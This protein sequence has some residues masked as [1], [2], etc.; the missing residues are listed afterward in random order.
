MIRDISET[1]QSL[2]ED[3]ALAGEF[4]DLAGAQISFERPA[5]T[6]N[7]PQTTVDLFLY[8]IKENTVLRTNEPVI[9]RTG[10]LA[11]VSQPP[12]RIDCSYLVTAFPVGGADVALQEHRLLS[13][14]LQV[15]SRHPT[16]P[17]AHLQG[18]LVSQEPPLPLVA[19]QI[20]GLPNVG[21]FWAALGTRIRAGYTLTVT[22]ALTVHPDAPEFLVTRKSLGVGLTVGAIEERFVQVGGQILDPAGQGIADALVDLTDISQRARTN[23]AGRYAF[24]HV[25]IGDHQMRVV[26][27]GFQPVTRAVSVPG[28]SEDFEVALTAI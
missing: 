12:R 21:E 10:R 28:R 11:T 5:D 16:V 9:Q 7:P 25:P 1:L 4:P 22:A 17:A 6:F 13:Q 8:E 18:S 20:D 14:T 19:A 24:P 26:A 27:T 15:L 3:P 2:L 23:G